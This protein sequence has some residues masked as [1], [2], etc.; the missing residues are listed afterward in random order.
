[1]LDSRPTK[2]FRLFPPGARGSTGLLSG[3]HV[4][5]RRERAT[6]SGIHFHQVPMHLE[7]S[8]TSGGEAPG[9][10]GSCSQPSLSSGSYN[11]WPG[12]G[13]LCEAPSDPS[14]GLWLTF[15]WL[16]QTRRFWSLPGGPKDLGGSIRNNASYLSVHCPFPRCVCKQP[17]KIESSACPV[18]LCLALLR[19]P[20]TLKTEGQSPVMNPAVT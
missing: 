19:C 8:R 1:M 20:V 12:P 2:T 17:Q 10:G 7:L 4:C 13:Q 3:G 16:P 18:L 11:S 14:R 6:L 15:P 9:Q 5:S